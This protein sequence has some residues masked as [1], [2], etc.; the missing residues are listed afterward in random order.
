MRRFGK[1]RPVGYEPGR[2]F[3]RFGKLKPIRRA[4]LGH[5]GEGGNKGR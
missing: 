1:L 2:P 5:K 3:K 4:D